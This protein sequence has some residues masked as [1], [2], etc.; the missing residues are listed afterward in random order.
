MKSVYYAAVVTRAYRKMI[1][2][3]EGRIAVDVARRYR[4][5]LDKVSHREFTTGFYY[6]RDEVSVPTTKSYQRQYLF[7]GT[8]GRRI[9]ERE[10]ELDI[11]NQIRTGEE[12]EFIGPD[13]LAIPDSSFE[14]FG[15]EGPVTQAD[16]GKR[17][18]VRTSASVEP[19]FLLRRRALPHEALA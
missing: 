15:E 17:Y 16:H 6:G 1:D 5:E 10:F 13:V 8:I 3:H 9:G 2:A 7:L 12:I 14:L 4:E 18:T 19:G 11:R